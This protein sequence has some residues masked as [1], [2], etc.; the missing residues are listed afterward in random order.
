VIKIDKRKVRFLNPTF[1]VPK[2]NGKWRKVLDCRRLNAE[3]REIHFRMNGAEVVQE[4]AEEEDW[5]TSHD[6]TNAFNHMLVNEEFV[7]YLAFSHRGK[8]Y[9]YAAIPSGSQ[10]SPRV[11]TRAFGYALAYIR[12][13]WEVRAVAYMDDVLYL[14]QSRVYLE[15]ATLQIGFYLQSLGWTFSLA[16]CEF[17]PKQEIRFFGWRWYFPTLS[18]NMTGEMRKD[19]LVSVRRWIV[20]VEKGERVSWRKL[21][22]L[23]GC[24]NFLPAQIPRASLYLRALHTALEW[25]GFDTRRVLSELLF[26]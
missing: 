21:A 5:A 3:Q 1:P 4:S 11:F 6:L 15:L 22:V 13:Y 8:Y 20:S 23:I 12:V 2:S 24:L 18:L 25:M 9:A 26:W 16:K 10:H 19:L 17:T 14:H 7:S